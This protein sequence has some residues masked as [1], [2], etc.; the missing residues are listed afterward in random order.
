MLDIYQQ[1]N[2]CV[3]VIMTTYNRSQYLDRSIQSFINQ[4][5]KNCELIIVDDGSEDSTFEVVNNYLENYNNI[6]YLKHSHRKN[7]L[8]KNAGIKAAAGKF[9]AFLD[10]DDE[11]KPDFLQKRIEYA[12]K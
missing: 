3:S 11:F 4:T 5:Y 6:R 12:G 10:S 7:F 9:I 8:S 2:P 1:S